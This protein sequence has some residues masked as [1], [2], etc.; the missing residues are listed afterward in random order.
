MLC[1]FTLSC[2]M[3]VEM[4]IDQCRPKRRSY[5]FET[6]YCGAKPSPFY[7]AARPVKCPV[8]RA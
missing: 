5:W 4:I 1:W 7:R 2:R 6:F 8:D 3:L